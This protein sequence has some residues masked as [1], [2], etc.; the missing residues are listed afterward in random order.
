MREKTNAYRVSVEK[1]E[2]N[3]LLGR[4]KQI[5]R[6]E[7]VDQTYWLRLRTSDKLL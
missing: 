5:L 6:W 3:R 1:P 7:G 4:L 2:G